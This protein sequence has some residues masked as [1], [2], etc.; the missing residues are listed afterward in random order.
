M[1]NETSETRSKQ[2]KREARREQASSTGPAQ[3]SGAPALN[4]GIEQVRDSH[5]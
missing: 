4:D 1:S 2:S 3:P 5:C